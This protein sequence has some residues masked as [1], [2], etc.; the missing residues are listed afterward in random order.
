MS[1]TAVVLPCYGC[2]STRRLTLYPAPAFDASDRTTFT[3]SSCAHCGLVRT[4]PVLT[5]QELARYYA[6]S[7]YGGG[8][9][10]FTRLVEWLTRFDHERRA[11]R[12]L[13]LLR[14]HAPVAKAPH[15]VIVRSPSQ[16]GEVGGRANHWQSDSAPLPTSPRWGEGSERLPRILDIGC[17]RAHLLSALAQQ[18]CECHGVERQD[19][20]FIPAQPGIHF[21]RDALE[22]VPLAP[23][24]FDAIVLWHVLE[25]VRNP[26]E[27]L[28]IA[29]KLLCPGGVLA[30]A[31][32][33]FGSWQA[34]LFKSA[35]FHLDLPRHTHHFSQSTLQPLLNQHHFKIIKIST[36]AFDQNVFGFIQSFLNKLAFSNQ[37][38]EL[39][40][41]LKDARKIDKKVR[42][43][44]WLTAAGIIFPLALLEYLSSGLAGKGASL[45]VYARKIS[46]E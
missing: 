39:Y 30:L 34:Q 44:T 24:S 8:Q 1:L 37:A 22:N 10:K 14:T 12:L 23:A 16:R 45:I 46:Q 9:Q 26:V 33:N 3:L 25:H 2:H 11:R 36:W 7:Y 4:E 6:S 15:I 18:G 32:P 38:N 31:V 20:P 17:G 42:L 13:A 19:F 35:W 27:T 29:A 43:L 5:D 40:S 21:Y 41:L 28:E